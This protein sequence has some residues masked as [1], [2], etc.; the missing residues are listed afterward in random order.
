MKIYVLDMD[1]SLMGAHSTRMST[2]SVHRL[3]E[4]GERN[5]GQ[6]RGERK[7]GGRPGVRADLTHPEFSARDA[8]TGCDE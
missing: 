1:L 7:D 4:S 3:A 6:A 8:N 2:S 5:S